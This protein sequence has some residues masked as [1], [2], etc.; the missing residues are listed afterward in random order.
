MKG[1]IGPLGQLRQ[2]VKALQPGNIEGIQKDELIQL[3]AKCWHHFEGSDEFKM[4]SSKVHRAKNLKFIPPSTIE[5]DIERHGP[6]ML[7]SVYAEVHHWKVDLEE[8]TATCNP[9]AGKRLVGARA[10]PLNIV[11]LARQVAQDIVEANKCSPWLE[12]KSN[13]KVKV[14]ISKLI[15]LM[16]KET[17]IKRRKRFR[18]ALEQLLQPHN[19]IPTSTFY[20]KNIYVKKN[21]E[22]VKS[23]E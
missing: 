5:F 4:D 19:W 7:G 21:A 1:S 13:T 12:W 14:L 11:L 15:P 20:S 3:L 2:Y 9:Y 22:S 16:V 17:T 6:T 18:K 10:K 23:T 8:C